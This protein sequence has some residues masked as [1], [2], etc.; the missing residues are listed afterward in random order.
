MD[1]CAVRRIKAIKV[2]TIRDGTPTTGETTVVASE[3]LK[4]ISSHRS[5]GYSNANRMNMTIRGDLYIPR[6]NYLHILADFTLRA[7]LGGL[8]ARC[9]HYRPLFG[10]AVVMFLI[11]AYCGYRNSG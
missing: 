10:R 6:H 2:R 7:R 11:D 3:S 4:Q 8:L 9:V 5:F 1:I